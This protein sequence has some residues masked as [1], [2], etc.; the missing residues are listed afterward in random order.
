[1]RRAKYWLKQGREWIL[2]RIVALKRPISTPVKAKVQQKADD[3]QYGAEHGRALKF[4]RGKGIEHFRGKRVG[5]P[6]SVADGQ[7]G[8]WGAVI[9]NIAHAGAV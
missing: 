9:D 1:M 8:T 6:G 3:R 4:T 5:A 2:L 7:Q